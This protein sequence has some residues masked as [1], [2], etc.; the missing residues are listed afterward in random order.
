MTP[1]VSTPC[2]TACAN[3]AGGADRVDRAQVVVV[4]ARRR[5]RRSS[6][7]RR[8]TC[9]AAPIRCRAWRA[10][11][12]RRARRSSRPRSAARGSTPAPVWMMAGPPTKRIFRPRA[13]VS[14]MP[15]ATAATVSSFGR[16]AETS[17]D[18]KPNTCAGSLRGAGTT[19]TASVVDEHAIARAARGARACRPRAAPSPVASEHDA[20]VHLDVLDRQPAA[21]VRTNVVEVGRRVEV[22]RGRRRPPA[23]PPTRASCA[24]EVAPC[25]PSSCR[26]CCRPSRIRRAHDD[27]RVAR[28]LA[29]RADAERA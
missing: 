9:R 20:A 7:G 23:R 22:R 26:M 6:A 18:M 16:S 17:L 5:A 15:R 14:A 3:A 10:R 28:L 21:A 27:L 24:G 25:W 8:A 11:C 29:R 19:F 2:S 12:R 1:R 4:A 13:R